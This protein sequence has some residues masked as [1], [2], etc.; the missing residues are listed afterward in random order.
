MYTEGGASFDRDVDPLILE[1]S[2]NTMQ[3]VVWQRLCLHVF[4]NRD[5]SAPSKVMICEILH[6][7]VNRVALPATTFLQY[8]SYI[9][10][11]AD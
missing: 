9:F 11:L 2:R 5:I 7:R 3:F 8:T 1:E 4:Q 6:K 10:L